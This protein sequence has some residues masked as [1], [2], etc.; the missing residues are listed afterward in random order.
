MAFDIVGHLDVIKVF[1]Y[2]PGRT[3]PFGTGSTVYQPPIHS[4]GKYGWA[5]NPRA[6]LSCRETACQCFQLDIPVTLGSD[7]HIEGDV[8]R[9]FACARDGQVT[10]V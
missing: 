3:L 7:A 5:A 9:D 6:N 10:A 1:G 4:G 8:A 2:R